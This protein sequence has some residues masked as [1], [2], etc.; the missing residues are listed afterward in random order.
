MRVPFRWP[1]RI[2]GGIAG[3]KLT[4]RSA[5]AASGCSTV[6]AGRIASRGERSA[7]L[8]ER[9]CEVRRMT[10]WGPRLVAGA[11]GQPHATVWR[12]CDGPGHVSPACG[13]AGRQTATSGPAQATS[14]TWMSARYPRFRGPGDADRRPLPAQP[15]WMDPERESATTTPTRSSTTTPAWPTSS[16][17][18]TNAPPR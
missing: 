4:R 15:H 10:G 16:S 14:C 12:V 11:A 2:G 7:E 5:R 8:E 1:R 9:I 17:T 18:T 13:Q 3:L 6:R